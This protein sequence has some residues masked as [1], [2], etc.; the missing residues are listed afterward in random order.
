MDPLR[1]QM[2]QALHS[3]YIHP[4]PSTHLY[5]I[6]SAPSL[7]TSAPSTPPCHCLPLILQLEGSVLEREMIHEVQVKNKDA[8]HRCHS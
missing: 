3:L 7:N 8:S 2:E 1:G 5:L 6:S 4:T